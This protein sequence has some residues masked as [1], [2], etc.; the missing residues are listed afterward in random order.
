[1]NGGQDFLAD[2]SLWDK[3][4]RDEDK[5]HNVFVCDPMF[6]T[7]VISK[8]AAEDCD[9]FLGDVLPLAQFSKVIIT[10]EGDGRCA[11]E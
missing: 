4:I 5:S 1:V 11:R 8:F 6:K 3:V 7:L 9:D 2:E 10:P